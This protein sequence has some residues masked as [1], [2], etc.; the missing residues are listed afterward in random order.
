MFPG[1][2][3]TGSMGA[4]YI[5]NSIG[6][7]PLSPASGDYTLGSPLFGNV[8]VAVGGGRT[9]SVVA[10]AQSPAH[11]AVAAARWNGVALPG[12]T[13]AYKDIMLGGL[14]EFFMVAPPATAAL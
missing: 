1:D 6:L 4:W 5:L 8:S 12:V 14:L 2:E 10:H 9:L 11:T 13:V 3:D 7:Y